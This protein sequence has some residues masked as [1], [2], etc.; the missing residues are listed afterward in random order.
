MIEVRNVTK[1]FDS[2]RNEHVIALKNVSFSVDEGQFV[3]I[4]GPSGCGKSTLLYIIAG[5]VKPSSG[6]VLVD[7]KPVTGPG[8]DRGLVF[9]EHA[10]FPWL[11]V[12]DNIKYGL[13]ELGLPKSEIKKVVEYYIDLMGLRGFERKYPKEL[14]GGM[15]QRVA[16]ART[17]AC[18]PRIILMDE[19]FGS[20]DAQMREILQEELLKLWYNSKKTIIFVTHSVEEAIYLSQK[21]IVMTYR[22]GTVKGIVD[23]N[24]SKS[25]DREEL[26][27]NN[28]FITLRNLIWTMVREE[29]LKHYKNA[30]NGDL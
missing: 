25:V 30:K 7:N 9:Q 12:Y 27:N 4:V 24:I 19:P 6:E 8:P 16:I 26:F 2:A 17:L 18:N 22:P 10:L 14:S 21:V 23:I 20:L 5:L 11:T 28:N 13:E 1:V 15:K 3:S 29:V